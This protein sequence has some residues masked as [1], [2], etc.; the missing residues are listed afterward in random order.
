MIKKLLEIKVKG[1]ALALFLKYVLPFLF[2]VMVMF[3]GIFLLLGVADSLFNQQDNTAPSSV[4]VVGEA[5]VDPAVEE[6][7][8]VFEKYANEFG[9]PDQV[10]ILMAKTQQESGG[11]LP[12]VMQSS[13]SA[14]L[15]M[16]TFT[17]KEESIEQGTKYWAQV[18]EEANGDVKLGLQSYNFGSGFIRYV[19]Q[20]YHGDYSEEAA[21]EFSKEQYEKNK[22][23]GLY[24]CNNA[25]KIETGACYGDFK[26]VEK[27]LGNI[28]TEADVMT[29]VRGEGSSSSAV[30]AGST[31][32]GNSDYVFGGGRTKAEQEAGNFDCSSFVHWAFEQ[33]GTDLGTLSG[34]TT[35][36]LKGQGQEVSYEDAQPGDMVFFDTYKLDGHVGIYVGDGQFIG[37]QESTGVAIES[38]E[39]GYWADTFN[40]RVK[41]V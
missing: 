27:V 23:S 16:N 33:V 13:E 38:M 37:A 26:Y 31:W 7:R 5:N 4:G 9:I 39:E 35:D 40:G 20:N 19:Q 28:N 34:V 2:V 12:D 22:G 3:V 41:R 17:S 10:D 14:G 29:T 8:P 36:S 15:P 6:L 32:I 25:D 30:Q 11:L 1:Y 18:L 21:I 24:K